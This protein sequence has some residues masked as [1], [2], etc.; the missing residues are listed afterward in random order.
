MAPRLDLDYCPV[1][2]LPTFNHEEVALV[3]GEY[4]H[5]F[6]LDRSVMVVKKEHLTRPAPTEP[7][8]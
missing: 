6:C 1:C 8:E 4:L 5:R 7:T 3:Q 2:D